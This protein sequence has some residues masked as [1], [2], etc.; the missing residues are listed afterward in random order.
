MNC[1]ISMTSTTITTTVMIRLAPPR[2]AHLPSSPSDRTQGNNRRAGIV[3]PGPVRASLRVYFKSFFAAFS[4][5]LPPFL[6]PPDFLLFLPEE[7]LAA[8]LISFSIPAML[9]T[10]PPSPAGGLLICL[11]PG[12]SAPKL[13]SEL[14]IARLLGTSMNKPSSNAIA[15]A[16]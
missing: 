14:P 3:G 15:C 12:D 11:Y 6:L 10:R 13:R 4:T 9:S 1:K 8:F 16:K 2:T 5:P 7:P